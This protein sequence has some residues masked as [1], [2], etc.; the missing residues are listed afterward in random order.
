M[1]KHVTRQNHSAIAKFKGTLMQ[2]WKSLY[3][4]VFIWK[5]DPDIFAFLILRILEISAR[6]VCK[7]LKKWANFE[8]VLLFLYVCKQSFHISHMRL[9]QKVKGVVMWNLQHIVFI[10]R[11]RY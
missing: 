9:S 11:R 2:I 4:S 6:E 5:Q 1:E 3:I 8:H 10:G 7:I